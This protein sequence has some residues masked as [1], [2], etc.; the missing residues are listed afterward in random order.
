MSSTPTAT[1]L[2]PSAATFDEVV[3]RAS[4]PV[5]VEFWAPWCGPCLA[6]KPIVE[7]VAGAR[8]LT[9]AF[10]DVQESPELAER[11]GI[12]SI[13]A[14]RLFRDGALLAEHIGSMS[15][16]GLVQWLEKHGT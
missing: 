12:H 1:F 8:G 3:L 7:R 5:L 4:G 13:P 15:T 14:L 6:F 2:H 11:F 10:V 9:T 16:A